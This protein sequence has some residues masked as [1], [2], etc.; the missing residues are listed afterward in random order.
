MSNLSILGRTILVI[1]ILG[2]A[3]AIAA[4]LIMNPAKTEKKEEVRAISVSVKSEAVRLG[5]YPVEI[6][7]LGQVVPAKET[8]LKAQVGGEIISVSDEFLPGG[9]FAEGDEIL[10]IDPS[11]YEL[12][13]RMQRAMVEQM[14]AALKLEKGQ[15]ATAQDELRILQSTTGKKLRNTDLALRK[16]QLAQAKAN[17]D[18]AKAQL[19]QAELNLE[20]T[21]I[22][23]PYNAILIVR[24][25]NLGNVISSQ[26]HLGTLVSTN[27][28]WVEIDV[29]VSDMRWLDIPGTKAKVHLDNRRGLREGSFLKM[30]GTLNEQSRLATMLV[31]VANPLEGAPLVLGDFVK[32][33]LV[34]KTLEQ[35]A[36]I[37]QSWLRG[38][39]TVWIKK[40]GKLV[41]QPVSVAHKDRDFAYI[42][43]GI[44]DGDNVITSNIVTPVDGMR[45]QP[46]EKR[47]DP[48]DG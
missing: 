27:T 17:L 26:D 4:L 18:S 29:P 11:D 3:G 36:R 25:T 30:T 8:I 20:R 22:K 9:F 21:V 32:V 41:I 35:A 43:S 37:P 46:I 34:G 31:S 40:D 28:Y 6:E 7:V 47:T 38:A 10:K 33:T 12:N 24:N 23:A 44:K 14:E 39:N 19:S 1:L 2:G 16:P 45:L 13:V 5:D 42:T 48:S 15:Q